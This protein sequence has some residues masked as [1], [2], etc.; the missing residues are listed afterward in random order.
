[1]ATSQRPMVRHPHAQPDTVSTGTSTVGE[2]RL[3]GARRFNSGDGEP[4]CE[5]PGVI[6]GTRNWSGTRP[7]F[8]QTMTSAWV[9]V[10]ALALR[11]SCFRLRQAEWRRAVGRLTLCSGGGLQRYLRR[12]HSCA[13]AIVGIALTLFG[14]SGRRAWRRHDTMV[15]RCTA[16]IPR[17]V[18]MPSGGG[19]RPPT[20]MTQA[21]LCRR[22]PY[23]LQ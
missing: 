7:S 10:A 13:A 16:D 11:L 8:A 22:Q 1:M 3:R 5:G 2:S 19:E 21:L 18:D 17:G 23:L 6:K 14:F 9:F 15:P 4:W 12:G 20:V